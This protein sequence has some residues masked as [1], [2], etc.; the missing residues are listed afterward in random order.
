MN[1]VLIWTRQNNVHVFR[2]SWKLIGQ[3]Q[4]MDRVEWDASSLANIEFGNRFA[5]NLH[6]VYFCL[7]HIKKRSF[8]TS[9]VFLFV[10]LN[11]SSHLCF[12]FFSVHNCIYKRLSVFDTGLSLYYL[13]IRHRLV[14]LFVYSI[15]ACHFICVLDTGLSL[16]LCIR[17]RLVTLF[18]YWTQACHFICLFDTG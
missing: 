15:Q 17:H 16:Y 2:Q 4:S 13:C 5:E 9:C 10:F 3:C 1:A 18:V 11:A 6:V 8:L 12:R 7:V 14:T